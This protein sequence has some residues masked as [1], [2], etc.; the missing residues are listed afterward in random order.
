MAHSKR[1][2]GYE[3]AQANRHQ[4]LRWLN[5]FGGL[6]TSQLSR[7][8]W[9]DMSSGQRMAQRTIHALKK[10]G[11][12]IRR[13]L[14]NGG[15]TYVLSERGSRL[16]RELG[17]TTAS[18]RG[19]RDLKFE[20]PMHRFICNEFAIDRHLEGLRIWT[21]FEIQRQQAPTPRITVGRHRKIPDLITQANDVYLSWVEVENA[22]KSQSRLLELV[23]VADRLLGPRD[24][25]EIRSKH[26]EG[27]FT[28]M[29]FVASNLS[30]LI[31]VSRCF[32]VAFEKH[33][34]SWDIARDIELVAVSMTERLRWSGTVGTVT[35]ETF[36][37]AVEQYTD[38]QKVLLDEFPEPPPRL[39]DLSSWTLWKHCVSLFEEDTV[40]ELCNEFELDTASPDA[41]KSLPDNKIDCIDRNQ[42]LAYLRDRLVW[43][44][45]D[46][47][48]NTEFLQQCMNWYSQQDPDSSS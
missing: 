41:L 4:V 1:P 35:L 33:L 16:L 39:E 30:R 9:P 14:P 29:V 38:I 24:G 22:Y 48:L 45:A 18:A 13:Q 40:E 28:N 26:A 36:L 17:V 19:Q 32:S 7:L 5:R 21:E 10:G 11:L 15:S 6:T 12:V 42:M 43:R 31:A 3:T 37:I 34:I 8:V 23:T 47:G 2:D 44:D 25:F 46:V 20:K 27:F